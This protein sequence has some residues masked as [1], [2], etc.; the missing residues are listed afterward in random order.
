MVDYQ[1]W[2]TIRYGGLSG[3]VDYQPEVDYQVWWTIWYGGLTGVVKHQ[4]GKPILSVQTRWRRNW[5]FGQCHVFYGFH[6]IM[7]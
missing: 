5:S 3:M 2:W 6:E 4:G 7:K 1:L